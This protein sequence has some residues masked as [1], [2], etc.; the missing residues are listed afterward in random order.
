MSGH[1][2]LLNLFA[3]VDVGRPRPHARRQIG[4]ELM[5]PRYKT[6]VRENKDTPA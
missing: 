3:V 5:R 1:R 6:A 4:D 2:A